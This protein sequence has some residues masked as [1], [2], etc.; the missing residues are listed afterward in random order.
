MSLHYLKMLF[1]RT[2]K[3]QRPNNTVEKI[4]MGLNSGPYRNLG[5]KVNN[6]KIRRDYR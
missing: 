5:G 6:R 3:G 2:V 4:M 1:K